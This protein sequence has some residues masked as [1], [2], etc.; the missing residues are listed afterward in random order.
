MAHFLPGG[1]VQMPCESRHCE[2]ARATAAIPVHDVSLLSLPLS[3][4][5]THYYLLLSPHHS[6][7]AT[8]DSITG[9]DA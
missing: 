4:L 6:R 1:S 5:S 2:G 9:C 7:L 8:T 3:L